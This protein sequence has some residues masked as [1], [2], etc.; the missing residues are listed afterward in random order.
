M[1]LDRMN[2]YILFPFKNYRRFILVSIKVSF[3]TSN[4]YV[5]IE[6]SNRLDK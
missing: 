6:P 2:M 1:Y 5:K 3:T 4:A